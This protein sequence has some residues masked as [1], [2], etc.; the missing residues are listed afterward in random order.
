MTERN[1]YYGCKRAEDMRFGVTSK[2]RTQIFS[3]NYINIITVFRAI[4]LQWGEVE[5]WRSDEN[6]IQTFIKIELVNQNQNG[7]KNHFNRIHSKKKSANLS[8]EKV[9]N[10]DCSNCS[11]FYSLYFFYFIFLL[12]SNFS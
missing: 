6:T 4:L 12:N 10:N 1:V 2:K 3:I 11:V 7:N 9:G 8:T 5:R